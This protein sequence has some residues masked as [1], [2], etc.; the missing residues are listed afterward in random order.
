MRCQ[1]TSISPLPTDC[2]C[3]QVVEAIFNDRIILNEQEWEDLVVCHLNITDLDGPWLHALAQLPDIMHRAR[4]HLQHNSLHGEALSQFA[5]EIRDLRASLQPCIDDAR[6]AL[7]EEDLGLL[8]NYTGDPSLEQTIHAIRSRRYGVILTAGMIINS[9]GKNFDTDT[10]PAMGGF[11]Y[12]GDSLFMAL[13]TLRLAAVARQ[14]KPLGSMYM[15]LCLSIA[16]VA[17]E[18]AFVNAAGRDLLREYRADF[19]MMPQPTALEN[20]LFWMKSRFM[21]MEQGTYEEVWQRYV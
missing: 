7:D 13:E 14:Y 20:E 18:D 2:I 19:W 3:V 8:A 16:C 9:L 15:I 5:N 10:D 11:D 4:T 21:L 6:A 17:T 12:A 1:K